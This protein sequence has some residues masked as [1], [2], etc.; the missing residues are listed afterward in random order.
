ML[1]RY[2]ALDLETTGLDPKKDRILEIGAVLVQD[3]R[4]IDSFETLINPRII[5][6]EKIIEV[7]GINNEM[8]ST[9]PIIEDVIEEFLKFCGEEV[10]LGHNLIFDF[11]F[12]KRAAINNDFDFEKLGIDTLKISKTCL[13][14]LESR[15]LDYLCKYFDIEDENHHRA[16]NDAI[17]AKRLYEIL[18]EK[19]SEADEYEPKELIYK[20]KK[21]GPITPAQIGYLRDLLVYHNLEIGIDIESLKKNEASRLIDN[22]ILRHGRILRKF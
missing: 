2:V 4:V 15:R 7:T 11:S 14:E 10:I 13:K 22:I 17:A 21:Y 12:I 20:V 9:A 1:K 6:P 8:V 3:G 5:I 16:L 18:C 19:Y